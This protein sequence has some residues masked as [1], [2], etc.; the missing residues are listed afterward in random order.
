MN[1]VAIIIPYFLNS[2]PPDWIRLNFFTLSRLSGFD[3]HY[4]TNSEALER[5]GEGV[6]NVRFHHCTF[7]DYCALASRRLGIDFRPTKFY[8]LCD[9][10]P[11]YG[12]IHSDILEGYDFWGYGDNDLVYGDMASLLSPQ[13][14]DRYDVITTM[15]E[16]VAGHFAI[17]R[18][19]RKYRE[20]P[21]KD[22]HWKELLLAQNH[23]GFD[24]SGWVRLVVPAK[25]WLTAA[26]KLLFR[27]G[28]SYWRWCKLTAP[29][30]SNRLTRIYTRERY[31]TPIPE[32]SQTW[33]LTPADGRIVSPD[34]KDIPYLHFLFFKKTQYLETDHYWK[35]GYWQLPD[36]ADFTRCQKI[37]FNLDGVKGF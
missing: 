36:D 7:D 28:C 5:L 27:H 4:F 12:Y 32:P 17:F 15:V 6:P 23:V 25:R 19:N 35:D 24:E 8:K 11:F 21:F 18:N 31:T 20:L 22:K 16:R 33:T 9:L 30:Y 2:T 3:V 37:T 1:R 34:G 14:L 13:M 26:Y 29:L 10:R